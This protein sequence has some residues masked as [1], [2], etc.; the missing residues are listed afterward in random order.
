MTIR[1]LEPPEELE[2]GPRQFRIGS[3][4]FLEHA[5][6]HPAG[7]LEIHPRRDLGGGRWNFD[8]HPITVRAIA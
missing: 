3:Q 8:L 2:L 4:L 1:Q 6:D 7:L 5:L